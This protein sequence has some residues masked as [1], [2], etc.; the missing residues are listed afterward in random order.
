MRTTAD[1]LVTHNLATNVIFV[2]LEARP[3]RSLSTD[4]RI[5]EYFAFQRRLE[6]AI[7]SGVRTS[8]NRGGGVFETDDVGQG[9]V[10]SHFLVEHL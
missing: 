7:R 8:V 4:V 3:P 9:G 5:A 1:E 2:R 10:L 6:R